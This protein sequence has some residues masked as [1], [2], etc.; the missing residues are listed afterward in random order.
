MWYY[1]KCLGHDT[2]VRQHYKSEHWAPCH[3][4]T[5][6]WYDWKIVESDVKPEYTHTHTHIFPMY[7]R[8]AE[9]MTKTGQTVTLKVA[10]QGAI[11]HGLATLLSQPSPVMPRGKYR[12]ASYFCT[13]P[14]LLWPE[15]WMTQ[16]CRH[17]VHEL[18]NLL[19][20]A[21][22]PI[23]LFQLSDCLLV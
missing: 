8:A 16:K 18:I 22:T 9:L 20:P 10:K 13:T 11:Y 12:M 3:N 7:F 1:V 5:P 23:F 4:Q 19:T 6:S 15:G 14:L 2:S 17:I 21:S